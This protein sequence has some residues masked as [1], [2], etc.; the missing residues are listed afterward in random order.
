MGGDDH[1][2]LA[3]RG[4]GPLDPPAEQVE[5]AATESGAVSGLPARGSSS[6]TGGM[7]EDIVVLV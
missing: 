4:K 7:V 6:G 3:D 2:Q 5:S 1:N